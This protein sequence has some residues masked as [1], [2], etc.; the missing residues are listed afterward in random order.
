[1]LKT[2]IERP[3]LSTVISILIVILGVLGLSALPVT[4]Y[5]DIAPPTVQIAAS[6]PGANAETVMQSVIIP[7]E[8]QV[9]GVENMDY[10]TSTASN[11]GSASIQVIFKQ[12]VDPDI[13]AVNVQ[14]RVARATPLLPAEVTRSG[15]TTQKQQ[16]SALMFLSFYST[17]PNY[18]AIYIQNYMNINVIPVLKRVNGIGDAQAFGSR[19]Y[20]M[21]VWIDPAKMKAYGLVPS[22]VVRVLNEQSLEAAAGQLGENNAEAFQYVIKYS[23]K[24]K[25]QEQYEGIVIKSLGNGQV[26]TLKDV[27]KIELGAMSYVGSSELNG[28]PAVAMAVYQ[29][30]GSNAQEIIQQLHKELEKMKSTFP[31]GIDYKILMDTNEFLDASIDKV[32]HTLIEAFILVFVVVYIFLQDFRSTLIPLIAVPVAIVGTF[33]FLSVFGFSLNL[34]TLFALVLAIGIV[35][36]DAI[37]VVEAVHAKMEETGQD[38]TEASISTMGEISGAIISITLVM[39]AVFIPVTFIPGPTGVFYKQFGITLIVAILI[40][41]INALTLSPALCALFLKQHDSHGEKKR[42]FVQRFFDAFNVAFNNLTH[43]YGNSFKFLLKHKWLTFV[44]LLG[45]LGLTYYSAKTMPSGFVPNEDRGFIMGNIE[46]PA[47]ASQDRVTSLQ[48]QFSK[49]VEQIPGVDGVTIVSGFSFIN[50]QGSNYGMA[51]IKL[52]DFKD[53]TTPDVATDAIIGKLFGLAATQFQD[54]RMIFFQPPSIPG[55][56]MSSGFEMK[57]L[58]KSGGSLTDFDQKSKEYLGELMKRPEIMYAQS[59]FNTNYAQYEMQLNIPRAKESGV[60]VSDIFSALQGYIGGIY[61]ADFTRFGKQYRVMVQSLPHYRSDVN[62]LNEIYVRTSS[63]QMAPVTQFVDLK[64]VYGPQSINR[65]NL[66]TSSNVAGAPKPGFSSGD[67]IR[68]AQEVAAQTLSTDYS[69]DFTGLSREEINSGNQTVMIFALCVIFVYFLLS[70]Q[71]ESYLLPLA[72]ILSLPTGIMGAFI[73]QKYAGLEN[74]IYFQIALVMLVGL[75]AKNAILIV[76]FAVQRRKH[77]E[78]IAESAINGAKARLRPILM[79][80]FAFI[81]GLM[82][83]VVASGVGS[84]GNRSIGT[85]AAFGLLIG[86]IIG[87]FVIPVLYAIFQYLQEKVKPIKFEEPTKHE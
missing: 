9:N 66:F 83:L 57:L 61:A 11:D 69:I 54:A 25:T 59:S 87:V 52:K 14:N 43:R 72:V 50:G 53:R 37:V 79:T 84:I 2:F 77:G 86:T 39:S 35:V 49:V 40:S 27:A 36:D 8:E 58:D 21:R 55:F 24:Y 34:L 3:V 12:G 26:L 75:L 13:A 7:I 62:S 45:C 82:P 71:Y 1:M 38:A 81:L 17:S 16:T 30:P 15:V 60:A 63:G 74:N 33:F 73:A 67:A 28:H 10:I 41:A 68:A 4:Q 29:T 76:E 6:Y 44:I 51:M 19:N 78:S 32:V 70:A 20:S 47:G 5:P 48:K 31:E 46:L 64:K 56:G 80:S 42:N 65:Y 18:D 85:G 23:G 22:D